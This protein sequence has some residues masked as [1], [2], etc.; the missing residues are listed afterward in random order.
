M[1]DRKVKTVGLADFLTDAQIVEAVRLFQIHGD[2][3]AEQIRVRVIAPN[4]VAIN[5]KLNQEND[6][7]YLAYA[8]VHA[9]TQAQEQ[10]LS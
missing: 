7:H 8:V 10:Q 2:R 5:A 3:A 6:P 1:A 9:L 4:M